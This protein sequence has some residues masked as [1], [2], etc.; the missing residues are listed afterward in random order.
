MA[1]YVSISEMNKATKKST[2]KKEIT[3]DSIRESICDKALENIKDVAQRKN[4]LVKDKAAAKTYY[5]L[6]KYGV[7]PVSAAKII[8]NDENAAVLDAT[9]YIN[10]VKNGTAGVNVKKDIELAYNK[11]KESLALAEKTRAETKDMTKEQKDAYKAT[12]A[13]AKRK[14]NKKAA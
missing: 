9:A 3:I 12:K 8:A 14:M 11:K 2:A 1:E 10:K 13:A 6:L 5:L 4:V 7:V